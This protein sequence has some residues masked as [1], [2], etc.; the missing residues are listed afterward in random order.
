MQNTM[1]QAV[2]Q[3]VYQ[4]AEVFYN[5]VTEEFVANASIEQYL[6]SLTE[7]MGPAWDDRLI[8]LARAFYT[9]A[10]AVTAIV[11]AGRFMGGAIQL[12][13]SRIHNAIDDLL[14]RW[15]RVLGVTD[16][17]LDQW[18]PEKE[19]KERKLKKKQIKKGEEKGE[20]EETEEET[21]EE[22]G[23]EQELGIFSME[24]DEEGESKDSEEN[25]EE[26]SLVKKRPSS[27]V[28]LGGGAPFTLTKR[29]RQQVSSS[30]TGL[31]HLT[32][33]PWSM[34]SQLGFELRQQLSQGSPSWF[35]NVNE[36]LLQNA[37][38]RAISQGVIQ[39]AEHFFNTS[40]DVF[41]TYYSE[42]EMFFRESNNQVGFDLG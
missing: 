35:A 27:E 2:T 19:R 25:P 38:V 34:I 24:E 3:K 37:V 36:V 33:L 32:S 23:E 16:D 10:K 12:G 1:V 9:T 29:I 40:M 26:T 17:M 18:L 11:G 41:R 14:T 7:R 15:D 28:L 42:W 8:P 21:E 31:G 20:E 22:V 6:D 39:P 30:L 4:P 5:T 13:K